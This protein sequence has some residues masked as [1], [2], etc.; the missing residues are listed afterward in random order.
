[1]LQADNWQLHC[2]IIVYDLARLTVDDHEVSSQRL[3]PAHNLL[4]ALLERRHVQWSFDPHGGWQI[5]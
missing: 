1:M 5:V 3:M 2:H 4:K